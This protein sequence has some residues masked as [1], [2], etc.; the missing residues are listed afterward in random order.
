[1]IPVSAEDI[2][3]AITKHGWTAIY[4][5]DSIVGVIKLTPIMPD[6]WEWGSLFVL[7]EFRSQKI[8]T[9]LISYVLDTYKNRALM[10][11]T[12]VDTVIKACKKNDQININIWDI[13]INILDAIEWPAKLLRDDHIFGNNEFFLRATHNKNEK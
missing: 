6:I 4:Q 5:G 2:M 9:L 8:G 3:T 7:P 11:V 13:D 12:N 10:C 1:M